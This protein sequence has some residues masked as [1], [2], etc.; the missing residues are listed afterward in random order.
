MIHPAILTEYHRTKWQMLCLVLLLFLVLLGLR[1]LFGTGFTLPF[2]FVLIPIVCGSISL[3]SFADDFLKGHI[4]FLYAMPV[5]RFGVWVVKC[6]FGIVTM[7][8]CSL[9]MYIALFTFP[10]ED[11]LTALNILQL[12]FPDVNLPPLGVVWITLALYGYAVGFFS[13]MMCVSLGSAAFLQ[14]NLLCTIPASVF[15]LVYRLTGTIP[16]PSGVVLTLTIAALSLMLGSLVLFAARNPYLER[17]L[18]RWGMGAGFIGV[19]TAV[20]C[21]AS[22]VEVAWPQAAPAGR[23]DQVITAHASLDGRSLAVVT[24]GTYMETH[25]YILTA[26]GTVEIDLGPGVSLLEDPALTWRPTARDPAVLYVEAASPLREALHNALGGPASQLVVRSLYTGQTT[27]VPCLGHGGLDFQYRR[28]LDGGQ[29]LLGLRKEDASG[30]GWSMCALMQDVATGKVTET[31]LA[32]GGAIAAEALDDN[33]IFLVRIG[34][35]VAI[36]DLHSGTTDEYNLPKGARVSLSFVPGARSRPPMLEGDSLVLV[37]RT[38]KK[39]GVGFDIIMY[40]LITGAIEV[41]VD[42]RDLPQFTLEQAAENKAPFH[43]GSYLSPSGRWLVYWVEE[44]HA[45]QGWM[46]TRMHLLR[47]SDRTTFD[48][49]PPRTRWN[50]LVFSREESRLLIVQREDMLFMAALDEVPSRKQRYLSTADAHLQVYDLGS[51]GP[52]EIFVSVAY[53]YDF[54]FQW[55]NENKIVYLHPLGRDS[56]GHWSEIWTIDLA[57]GTQQCVECAP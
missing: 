45:T 39:D 12:L 4:R 37:R 14:I 18:L 3:D 55:L 54:A 23:L 5:S 15:Y 28:W 41:L 6:L 27:R 11:V 10:D 19:T 56:Q 48:L 51:D 22:A 35:T 26:D 9:S 53:D 20:L 16:S 52:H 36:V 13:V 24:R 34:N 50:E 31:L 1:A 29:R 49:E 40:N 21:G 57:A 38:I 7:C 30:R 32:D 33:R 17:R 46:A 44:P 42:R 2:V 8:L 47:L 25:G 43:V